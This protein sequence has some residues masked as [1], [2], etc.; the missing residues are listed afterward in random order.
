MAKLTSAEQ[1]GLYLA[2][3]ESDARSGSPK[4]APG[5]SAGEKVLL[6]V[7]VPVLGA[8]SFI[9]DQSDRNRSAYL[10]GYERGLEI[11]KITGK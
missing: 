9:P 6:S 7:V 5:M 11:R 4:N 8:A 2:K 1:E 3:G 10:D